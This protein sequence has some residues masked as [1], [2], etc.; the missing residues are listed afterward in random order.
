MTPEERKAAAEVMASDG[1]WQMRLKRTSGAWE[2]VPMP[3]WD[4]RLYDYRVRPK[5][6]V[7]YFNFYADDGFAKDY[8]SRQ[9]ADDG[10]CSS[11]T[12]CIRV[13]FTPGQFD[14]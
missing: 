8:K 5:P 11:R 1:P 2:D 6:I 4:W 13:R 7:R 10:S 3:V 9:E 14:E 12:A